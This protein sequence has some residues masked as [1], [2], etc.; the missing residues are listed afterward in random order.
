MTVTRI[1]KQFT[2]EEEDIAQIRQRVGLVENLGEPI[3]ELVVL[4][5]FRINPYAWHIFETEGPNPQ[6]TLTYT[7]YREDLVR[8]R[9][10]APLHG[11]GETSEPAE[12][13]VE[14]TALLADAAKIR[15]FMSRLRSVT[16]PILPSQVW[17][18]GPDGC[19]FQLRLGSRKYFCQLNYHAM[20]PEWSDL[21]HVISEMQADF[22]TWYPN[23]GCE[24]ESATVPARLIRHEPTAQAD[25]CRLAGYR[26]WSHNRPL[27]PSR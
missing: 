18:N 16:I 10:T 1:R 26:V 9:R 8:P 2:T 15:G 5:P 20:P 17:I 27:G 24:G 21:Q 19:D 7:C 25:R 13:I 22:E 12:P 11:R 6:C 3:F 14:F 23:P 4:C